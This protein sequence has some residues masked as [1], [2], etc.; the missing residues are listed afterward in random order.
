LGILVDGEA[1]ALIA[2][3]QG[4]ETRGIQEPQKEST[5]RGSKE[6]FVENIRI[7]T[8]LIRRRIVHLNLKLESFTIGTYTQTEVV[9][10]YMQG[11]ADENVLSEVRE[12]LARL[13]RTA[14]STPPI[15]KSG[16]RT[17]P[18]PFSRKFRI[19]NVR[20]L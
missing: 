15:S 5:L 9:L 4:Y 11:L 16:W 17:A 1:S 19:P 12:K 8:S 14:S 7:N 13:R 20:I 10:A 2:E 6:G 3:V 18:S